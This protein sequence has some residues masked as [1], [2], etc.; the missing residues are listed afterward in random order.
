[1]KTVVI[2]RLLLEGFGPFAGTV[3]AGF[4]P[5]INHLVR[6]NERGKSSLVYGLLAVIYGMPQLSDPSRFGQARFRNRDNPARFRGEVEL[7]INGVLHRIERDF[8][9]N[10]VRLLQIN[11]KRTQQR[12]VGVHNPGA[13]RRNEHYEGAIED[14]LGVG[15]RETFE[16]TF[17][18]RQ[19]IPRVREIS[20]SVQQLLSGG[21]GAFGDALS[22][23]S[24]DLE[25]L[26]R[27]TGDRGV[28]P[29]NRIQ[30]RRL[31]KLEEEIYHLRESIEESRAAVDTLEEVKKRLVEA[32]E[33][34]R[35]KRDRLK[36]G[37]HTRSGWAEWRRLRDQYRGLIREQVRTDQGLQEAIALRGR[38]DR[39]HGRIADEYPEFEGQPGDVEEKIQRL[40]ALEETAEELQ[41]EYE[42]R[43]S[44]LERREGELEARRERLQ[45]LLSWDQITSQPLERVKN[46]RLM[47]GEVLEEWEEFGEVRGRIEGLHSRILSEYG[48]L[49]T[50]C[51]EDI[52][53]LEAHRQNAAALQ[54]AVQDAG[55][56][57]DSLERRVEDHRRASDAFLEEFGDLACLDDD[58]PTTVEERLEL[59]RR[60]DHLREGIRG[61]EGELETPAPVRLLAAAAAALGIGLPVF[62]AT[63]GD[64]LTVLAVVVFA[65]GLLGYAAAGRLYGL[66]RGSARSRRRDML[67]DLESCRRRAEAVDGILGDFASDDPVALARLKERLLHR[68]RRAGAIDELA[69]AL[70]PRKEMESA[71]SAHREAL[72]KLRE[73]RGRMERFCREFDDVEQAVARWRELTEKRRQ[74]MEDQRRFCERS[75]DCTPEEAPGADLGRAGVSARW[76]ETA[77][78]LGFALGDRCTTPGQLV[79][80]LRGVDDDWWDETERNAG[81][82]SRLVEEIAGDA[83]VIRALG[84]GLRTGAE[85]LADVKSRRDEISEELEEVLA[86]AGGDAYRARARFND[87]AKLHQLLREHLSTFDELLRGLGAASLEDLREKAA[88]MRNQAAHTLGSWEGV[89]AKYPGL[90][91]ISEADEV[92]AIQGRLDALDSEIRTLEEEIEGLEA[93][94]G[95]LVR[96]QSRLEGREPVNIARAE[97]ELRVLE[98]EREEALLLADSMTLAHQELVE[99]IR[100][101][102]GESRENL[103]RM[104]N[105]YYR[106]I[107]GVDDRAVV[108]GDDFSITVEE[109]GA[110]CA[111]EQLSQGASDQLYLSLRFAVGDLLSAEVGLPFIFDDPFVSCDEGRRQG[112]RSVLEDQADRRQFLILSHS[113]EFSR[114]GGEVQLKVQ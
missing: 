55:Q 88:D 1:M 37:Q 105:L 13:I 24:V 30:D 56:H 16:A 54:A 110:V 46:V 65:L 50:A 100:E 38:A 91:E 7:V 44:E 62:G 28:T 73:Y 76:R 3:E 19:P 83:G 106:S 90:P 71:R 82:Y 96:S 87:R 81:E 68:D 104:T 42:G 75:F 49:E 43:V 93:H 85:R 22:V 45:G 15:S 98:E 89:L 31:E 67:E 58:A 79:D 48:A 29:R 41:R 25:S 69:A 14:L 63:G 102:Q 35:R 103:Q 51:E 109:G 32:E 111:L 78:L 99:A 11:G 20:G 12:V 72:D 34:L 9:D 21:G 74:L 8:D 84:D 92:E 33:E 80:V 52:G 17:C 47:A 36:K 114:W 10:R 39:L 5:G 86:A 2:R 57:L 6:E 95:E 108:I 107:T 59:I 64:S 113:D 23:L 60:M 27:Y 77:E 61:C 18:V 70:P 97:T 112:L 66:M 26:T 4:S 101:F 94:A 53:A 40:V